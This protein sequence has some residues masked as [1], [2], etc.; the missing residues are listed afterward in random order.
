VITLQ[1]LVLT[2]SIIDQIKRDAI[3]LSCRIACED[4]L[5][6]LYSHSLV[7]NDITDH[8]LTIRSYIVSCRKYIDQILI[9]YLQQD[10]RFA[11]MFQEFSLLNKKTFFLR[12]SI[13]LMFFI[14][15]GRVLVRCSSN[16]SESLDISCESSNQQGKQERQ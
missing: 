6:S 8:D 7:S 2:L 13:G 1:L 11:K 3:I 14:F 9:S 10:Y 12:Q 4:D 15:S 5:C 16:D